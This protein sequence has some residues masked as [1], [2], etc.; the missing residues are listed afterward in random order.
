MADKTYVNT[1]KTGIKEAK[2]LEVM[3]ADA[4]KFKAIME[5]IAACDHPEILEDE[6]EVK[7]NE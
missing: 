2:M 3:M 4:E 5:Y 7:E 6:S 1:R